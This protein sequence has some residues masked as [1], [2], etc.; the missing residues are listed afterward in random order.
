MDLR[1]LSKVEDLKRHPWELSRLS[2]SYDILKKY[3]SSSSKLKILDLGCGD[4]FVVEELLKLFP[5]S[6]FYAVDTAFT[7][8]NLTDLS[9]KHQ[10]KNIFVYSDL[11]EVQIE[12]ELSLILLMDVIEHI[13]NDITFMSWLSNH[14]FVTK[15]TLVYITVPAYQSLFC[16][17]DVFLGHYRRYDNQLLQSN[18]KTSGYEKIEI[19]YFFSTLLIARI[20]QVIKEKIFSPKKNTTGLVEWKSSESISHTVKN[21]LITDYN[22]SKWLKGFGIKI[23]GLSNYI[24][25]QKSV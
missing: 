10:G 24:I 15:N 9:L 17:H 23:P 4:T 20:L 14:S 19:G 7:D 5:N 8:A 25:C 18:L 3:V 13:E 12:G 16:S 22:F 1:E 2:I 11:S 6:T 21:V